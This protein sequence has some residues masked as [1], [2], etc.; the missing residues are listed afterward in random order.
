MIGLGPI[1]SITLKSWK[2]LRQSLKAGENWPSVCAC[3]IFASG[4][5]FSFFLHFFEILWNLQ[6][7]IFGLKIWQCKILDKYHVWLLTPFH[8]YRF[9]TIFNSSLRL[10][11]DICHL[12]KKF[13]IRGKAENIEIKKRQSRRQLY[14][15]VAT[16]CLRRDRVWKYRVSQTTSFSGFQI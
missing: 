8:M 7:K 13:Y 1:K 3:K 16:N 12:S 15:P 4:L 14:L 10:I 9:K 6:C 2:N 5:N 11:F